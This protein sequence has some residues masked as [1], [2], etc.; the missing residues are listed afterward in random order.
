MRYLLLLAGPMLAL[1]V[2]VLGQWLSGDAFWIVTGTILAA[3]LAGI[4]IVGSP[5]PQTTR[6]WVRTLGI[7]I[8]ASAGFIILVRLAVAAGPG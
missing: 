8:G 2:A 4:E 1:V 5:P 7:S 3:A 6:W